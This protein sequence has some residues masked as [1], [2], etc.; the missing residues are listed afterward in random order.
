MA[1]QVLE[2]HRRP[3]PRL[4]AV[5]K[6]E[7]NVIRRPR[8]EKRTQER[9]YRVRVSFMFLVRV[10]MFQCLRQRVGHKSRCLSQKPKTMELRFDLSVVSAPWQ[11][12]ECQ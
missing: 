2:G 6:Y 1:G 5:S 10:T 4:V 12:Q 8:G 3:E 7:S 9:V 11:G